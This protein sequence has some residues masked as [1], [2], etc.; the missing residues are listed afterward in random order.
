MPNVSKYSI[1]TDC[2]LDKS[3][4]SNLSG[5]RS[6]REGS[7]ISLEPSWKT[8]QWSAS[9]HAVSQPVNKI[10]LFTV[11]IHYPSRRPSSQP[12]QFSLAPTNQ[13][14]QA[15]HLLSLSLSLSGSHSSG[16]NLSRLE[17]SAKGHYPGLHV[18]WAAVLSNSTRCCC[19]HWVTCE[20]R[21]S[22]CTSSYSSL[23]SNLYPSETLS[24]EESRRDK[25]SWSV[26]KERYIQ[27]VVE[28]VRKPSL[29]QLGFY[30]MKD[31]GMD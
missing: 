21:V 1:S 13:P 6:A 29:N 7:V 28:C 25:W 18:C 9:L 14:P 20:G 22:S 4:I 10:K 24:S 11:G 16:M 23:L 17:H 2:S 15:P 19:D 5:F 8:R 31:Y 26:I 3:L 30:L 12:Q 27:H